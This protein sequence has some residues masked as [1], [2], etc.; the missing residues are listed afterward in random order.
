[1]SNAVSSLLFL[2]S[3]AVFTCVSSKQWIQCPNG[4]RGQNIAVLES[5]N[6]TFASALHR[7]QAGTEAL[8]TLLHHFKEVN[9]T[10]DGNNPKTG[11]VWLCGRSKTSPAVTSELKA[12]QWAT[13]ETSG[14][15][16]FIHPDTP[17]ANF[18]QPRD[19]FKAV[20]EFHL[21]IQQSGSAVAGSYGTSW[22]KVFTAGV[23]DY[24]PPDKYRQCRFARA[25]G[26]RF[27]GTWSAS[28][29]VTNYS[30]G[31]AVESRGI[32]QEIID[33][34]STS[35]PRAKPTSKAVCNC[36]RDGACQLLRYEN[37]T[38]ILRT[39]QGSVSWS[40]FASEELQENPSILQALERGDFEK[41]MLQDSD[42]FSSLSILLLPV[43]LAL[44]P[45]ALFQDTTV[46]ATVLYAV[47]T[48]VASVMP[49]AIKGA[50]LVVYG[51]RK[52]YAF[53]CNMYNMNNE[54]STG[55]VESWAAECS[56]KPFVRQKGIGLLAL[57]FSVMILGIILEV[58]ARRFTEKRRAK[59]EWEDAAVLEH[60]SFLR[61]L[62]IYLG[63][64]GRR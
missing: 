4:A 42:S 37:G 50:E 1:M 52:H 8:N 12:L 33:G 31:I 22:R 48:D 6:G 19:V 3:S 32:L 62:P 41:E 23:L 56:V 35:S 14:C 40:H 24:S 45:I 2:F 61:Q 26:Y 25:L 29:M 13:S 27:N 58:V 20:H 17:P 15:A 7:N 36:R 59:Q 16:Y 46:L 5:E 47:A 9:R 28:A 43:C 11:G 57:A 60:E 49:I 34:G 53:N 51:S 39:S 30:T 64:K 63:S 18:S 21:A 10:I 54:N 44:V 55:V 38:G